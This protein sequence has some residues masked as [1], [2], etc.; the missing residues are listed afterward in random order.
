LPLGIY[1]INTQ[2]RTEGGRI[3]A[4][5][6]HG[7]TCLISSSPCPI[8]KGG[9]SLAG[10]MLVGRADLY[11]VVFDGNRLGRGSLVSQCAVNPGVGYN[12]LQRATAGAGG[13]QIQGAAI[14]NAVCGAG[15]YSQIG[16]GL[17][18]G[19]QIQST[20]FRGN[21]VHDDATKSWANGIH[22]GPGSNGF[23]AQGNFYTDNTD[24]HVAVDEPTSSIELEQS[25][26]IM[27]AANAF[28]GIRDSYPVNTTFVGPPP[29]NWGNQFQQNTITCNGR[30]YFGI[31]IGG[32]PWSAQSPLTTSQ[33][34]DVEENTVNGAVVLINWDAGVGRLQ[35]NSYGAVLGKF[36]RCSQ[37]A[38][39]L[40]VSPE[41]RVDR[42][43][44]S[45]PP[46]THITYAGCV[47]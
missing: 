39:L 24:C 43:G 19:A 30:C 3:E 7:Q 25:T 6:F 4:N 15:L 14:I 37:P 35:Q 38:S 2:L 23:Q 5:D 40:N 42:S 45:H 20:L 8:L 34:I 36:N 29:A 41:S 32:R 10:P 17:F 33:G 47:P 11:N 27:Q 18:S 21:G 46:A 13:F 1:L 26:Y 9:P 16:G 22:I 28:A 31:Q 44:E 12:I